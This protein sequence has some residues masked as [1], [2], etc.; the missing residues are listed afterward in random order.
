MHA[1]INADVNRC[2]NAPTS[3]A[4]LNE[5]FTGGLSSF[6]L[7]N[8][9]LAHLQCEGM[10]PAVVADI[11]SRVPSDLA[12][13]QAATR[14]ALAATTT[15]TTPADA[16]PSAHHGSGLAVAG[17]TST[18]SAVAAASGGGALEQHNTHPVTTTNGSQPQQ[19]QVPHHHQQQRRQ[20]SCQRQ[21]Q[22]PTEQ[23]EGEGTVGQWELRRFLSHVQRTC[24]G[25][26]LQALGGGTD[27][28]ELLVALLYRCGLCCVGGSCTGV[29]CVV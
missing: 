6:S 21:L 14:A 11:L 16:T 4:G 8:L 29:V 3:P 10:A 7:F 13:V 19:Q 24:M 2:T 27:L 20:L 15:T 28:G 26:P 9:V 18:P 5:V 25:S 17:E 23:V 1:C 12:E 22:A